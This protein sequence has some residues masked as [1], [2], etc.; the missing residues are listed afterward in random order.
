MSYQ[1]LNQKGIGHVVALLVLVFVAVAGFAGYTVI[2]KNSAVEPAPASTMQQ[3]E[4]DEIRNQ[5]DLEKNDR[6][7][8]DSEQQ[9]DS[10]LDDSELDA[11]LD[12]ML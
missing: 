3:T 6:E 8:T 7:L 4:S 12:A 10:Q 2:S 11:D 5:S 1:T 9:L